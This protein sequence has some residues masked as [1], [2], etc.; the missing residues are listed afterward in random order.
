VILP[1]DDNLTS[2]LLT[3]V[4]YVPINVVVLLGGVNGVSTL[5]C[6]A[7]ASYAQST[8]SLTSSRAAGRSVLPSR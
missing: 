4:Q 7:V 3:T 2:P 1:F 6:P 5:G 8:E